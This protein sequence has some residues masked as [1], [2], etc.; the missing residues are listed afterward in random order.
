M[1]VNDNESSG[2]HW[3]VLT[4]DG[5]L[6]PVSGNRP[7]NAWFDYAFISNDLVSPKVLACA[8]DKGVIVA[9]SW[10]EYTSGPFR[11]NSTSFGINVDAGADA[12][13]G[14]PGGV[15]AFDQAQQH[16]LFLDHN[17]NF[18]PGAVGCSARVNNTVQVAD[19][20]ART[21]S[22]YRWTN[23]VHGANSGNIATM[24]GSVHQTTTPGMQE[25]LKHG[26]DNG[27]L[28]FLRGRQ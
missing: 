25:F 26:D 9:S 19:T 17:L 27:N 13:S 21:F 12:S 4:T 2:A 1:W 20:G 8:S 7:G 28:H 18:N 15:I 6:R 11:A 24:D 3:R 10:D 16:I 5:G 14:N 23:A 22:N